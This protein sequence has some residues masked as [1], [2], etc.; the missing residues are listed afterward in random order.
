[1]RGFPL[2]R[3]DNPHSTGV[4]S[5]RSTGRA[6]FKGSASPL[7]FPHLVGRRGFFPLQL[8]PP[9]FNFNFNTILQKINTYRTLF[10]PVSQIRGF[11]AWVS[12]NNTL[13]L[14]LHKEWKKMATMEGNLSKRL[15]TKEDMYRFAEEIKMAIAELQINNEQRFSKLEKEIETRFS[16][17]EKEV[18]TLK[19]LL[20]FILIF[21]GF[22]AFPQLLNF[23]KLL[24]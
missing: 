22:S 8:F 23:L 21:I 18:L 2:H 16:K 3:G 10:I 9:S 1:M 14:M 15:A 12:V 6:D 11:L 20:W 5:P 17:L 19:L 4:T 13:N 7:K 24:K